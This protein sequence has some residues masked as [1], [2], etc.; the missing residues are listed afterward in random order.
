MTGLSHEQY[1]Q[2]EMDRLH[3]LNHGGQIMN[4]DTFLIG[5]S[6]KTYNIGDVVTCVNSDFGNLVTYCKSLPKYGLNYTV[7]HVLRVFSPV[8]HFRLIL[9]E[10]NNDS[11]NDDLI[12]YEPSFSASNFQQVII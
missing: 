2:F 11:L 10:I 12:K 1:L 5:L 3:Y 4:N 7:K 9:C 8:P 6:N